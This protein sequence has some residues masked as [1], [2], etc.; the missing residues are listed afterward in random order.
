VAITLYDASQPVFVRGLGNLNKILEK[1][2]ASAAARKIDP[3]VL[4]G[5]RLYPDMFPLMRQ[6]WIASDTAKASMARLSGLEAPKFPDVETTFEELHARIQKTI[7]YVSGFSA[8][9]LEGSETRTV[10]LKLPNGDLTFNGLSYLTVFALP[11]FMFHLATAYNILRHNG[12]EL[13]KMDFL[14]AR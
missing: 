2:A 7:D 14:G 13:G 8:T 10:V 12:V 4:L 11:N 3:A 6:V 9:Q 5:S 1:G